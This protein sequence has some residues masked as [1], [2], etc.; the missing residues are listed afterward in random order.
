MKKYSMSFT[1]AGLLRKETIALAS[2]YLDSGD[3]INIHERVM[4]DNVLQM[5]ARSSRHRIFSEIKARLE[6]LN[7]TEK[8]ILCSPSSSDVDVILWLALC[9]CYPFIGDFAR[10]VLREKFITLQRYIDFSDYALFVERESAFHPEILNL[11]DS[12]S[13]RLRQMLF[14]FLRGCGMLSR[15]N[16]IQPVIFSPVVDSLFCSG[17][18]S[19][20]QYYPV[21]QKVVPR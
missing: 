14:Q 13:R 21:I 2:L 12:T 3:W 11:R 18:P 10:E 7:N 20:I 19:E 9:R 5:K 1:T 6:C 16:M 17:D 4:I 8:Q 15:D